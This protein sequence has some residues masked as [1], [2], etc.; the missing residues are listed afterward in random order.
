MLATNGRVHDEMLATIRTF[1]GRLDG[2]R[3]LLTERVTLA[4]TPADIATRQSHLGLAAISVADSTR[5][6]HLQWHCSCSSQPLGRPC[7]QRG[8]G[9]GEWS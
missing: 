3:R 4:A 6:W 9:H 1:A 7:M 8:A 5:E 2:V